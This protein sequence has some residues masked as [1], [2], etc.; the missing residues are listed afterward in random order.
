MASARGAPERRGFS[1]AVG[2]YGPLLLALYFVATTRWGSYLLPGPPYIGDIALAGLVAHRAWTLFRKGTPTPLLS[3]TLTLPATLLL[4]LSA[5]TL[6]TGELSADGLRDAAPY[7]YA[8][9][10]LFG[11]SYRAISPRVAERL[12]FGA[13]LILITWYSAVDLFPGLASEVTVPGGDDVFLFGQRGDIS[14]ALIG[15]LAALA[16]DRVLVGRNVWLN[17][18]LAAWALVVVLSNQS[19]SAMLATVL[20]FALIG[21]RQLLLEGRRRSGAGAIPALLRANAGVALAVLVAIPLA[22]TVLSGTPEAL[23]RSVNVVRGSGAEDDV[24]DGGVQDGGGTRPIYGTNSGVGTFTARKDAWAEI[25]DWINRDGASRA[26]LGVGF[27]P[28]YLQLSGGDVL[29]LGPLA[30]PDVRAAHNFGVNTWARLGA[31]GLLLITSIFALALIAALRLAIRSRTPPLLDLFA[32]LLV[33]AIPTTALLGVVLESPFGAIPYFWAVGYLGARMVEEGLWR[34][35]PMPAW[36]MR[37]G[38]APQ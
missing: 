10:M 34:R 11:Q 31:I 17:A 1:E 35:V 15:V 12:V 6:A 19:R 32:A 2:L 29:L 23:D 13:L 3:W 14:G 8:I 28:H 9:L 30:D 21:L 16:L 33:I 20:C 25:V 36:L 38:A 7:F 4:L 27:G 26:L 18:G 5:A 37:Q 24:Q 22:F